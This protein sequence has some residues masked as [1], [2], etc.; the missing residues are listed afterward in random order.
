MTS[1]LPDSPGASTRSAAL[2]TGTQGVGRSSLLLSLSTAAVAGVSYAGGLVM[3]H[4]L[5]VEGIGAFAADQTL[6]GAVGVVSL[7]L[8]P[9]PL[10]G[11][12]RSGPRGSAERRRGMA[13]AVLVSLLLGLVAAT[14]TGATTAL[15]ASAGV[16]MAVAGSA[17]SL[18]LVAAVWG[19]LQGE[20]RFLTYSRSTI[21]EVG[22][23][24]VISVAACLLAWGAGGALAHAVMAVFAIVLLALRA[25]A[26][27][28]LG[29]FPATVLVP[30]GLVG[31][32]QLGGI[33]GLAVG[34]TIGAALA[35][36]AFLLLARPLLPSGTGVIRAARSSRAWPPPPSTSPSQ[37]PSCGPRRLQACSSR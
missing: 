8:I 25:Y 36:V 17:L 18:S 31:G 33:A 3:A 23:R 34:G 30:T 14:L 2:S 29:L 37:I 35:S 12:I 9:L 24:L 1:V 22:A 15:F 6:L 20:L 32:G 11:S 5:D 13:F 28:Q 10:V 27:A 16:A 26:R 4:T 19:W 21:V 7:A